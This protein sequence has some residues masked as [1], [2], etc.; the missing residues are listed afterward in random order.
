[1]D[2]WNFSREHEERVAQVT[3]QMQRYDCVADAQ[4]LYNVLY[5]ISVSDPTHWEEICM[6]LSFEEEQEEECFSTTCVVDCHEE[7]FDEENCVSTNYSTERDI[8]EPFS[9]PFVPFHP[10][11]LFQKM[12]RKEP[13]K[14]RTH[15]TTTHPYSTVSIQRSD[16]NNKL[17]H[18]I[19][20][21]AWLWFKFKELT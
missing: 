11:D 20:S 2:L 17:L 7:V 5:T 18:S 19:D 21:L 4:E 3:H 13:Y 1:M 15:Q 14:I 10:C 6:M 12:Y 8:Q 16:N 9:T